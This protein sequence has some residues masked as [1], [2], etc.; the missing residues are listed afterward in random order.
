L[1]V[2]E[3]PLDLLLQ[4]IQRRELDI[5]AVALA[6]VTD[7]YLEYVRRLEE[8]DPGALAEF[9]VVAAKLILIKSRALLP[10]PPSIEDE[11]EEDPAEELARR[12]IE[13]RKFKAVAESLQARESQG[14]RAYVRTAAPVRPGQLFNLEG[15]SLDDLV[16]AFQQALELHPTL[17]VSEEVAPLT[18]SIDDQIRVILDRVTRAGEISFN[19]FLAGAASRLEVIVSFLALLELIKQKRV[20]VRQ[21]ELFGEIVV[22]RWL[23]DA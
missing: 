1:E 23:A 21:E 20:T 18:V 5:T 17:A 6:Q 3:G 15:V 14:L 11:E 12:L 22:A 8:V 4:L 9:L 2:F 16:I 19:R 7:Q 10:Q 13:Y